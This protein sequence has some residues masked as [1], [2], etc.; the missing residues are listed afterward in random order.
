MLR[1]VKQ[2]KPPGLHAEAALIF[3]IVSMEILKLH[4]LVYAQKVGHK[5]EKSH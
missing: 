2:N 4:S 3:H 5:E 1:Q